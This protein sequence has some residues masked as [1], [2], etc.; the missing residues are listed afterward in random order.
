MRSD[1][2]ALIDTDRLVHNYRALRACCGP[3]VRLCAPLKA[4][5]YGHGLAIVAPALQAAGADF[6]AVATLAEALEL[7]QVGWTGAVLV[8]G[9]VLAVRDR[10]ERR[11]RI[12]A[13][14]NARLT[15]TIADEAT[16]ATLSALAP[17]RPIDVHLKIDTGMGRMGVLP[18]RACKLAQ[19]IRQVP[20][21]RLAGAYSH[22]ATADFEQLDLVTQQLADFN[23]A[24]AAIGDALPRGAV[25]H[26]ANSAATLSLPEAHFEMVRPG[27]ALYGYPPAGHLAQGVDLRPILRVVSHLTVVKD[28]PPGHGVGYGR[29]FT[30]SRPTRL[31]LV[32][33]GYFDGYLRSLSNRAVVTT[34]VGDA[35]VIGRVSMDQIAVDLT[36]LPPLSP[37]EPV[38]LINDA[39]D[40]PN[41]LPAIARQIQTIPYEVMT[42]LG[43]RIQRVPAAQFPVF[44]DR[45]T[46]TS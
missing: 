4:N 11:E 30:T 43:A 40:R 41:S 26:I 42:L 14:L 5:A 27:L 7:R 8:L 31:G 12:D 38:M 29:T 32:P 34:A 35:P 22:F 28:L 39:P 17:P 21:L 15:L 44:S 20:H 3:D 10:T 33:I 19:A 23:D 25:R 37:G 1:V 46:F 6:A 24:I 45:P 18:D 16:V 36:D 9:A 13:I 2:L